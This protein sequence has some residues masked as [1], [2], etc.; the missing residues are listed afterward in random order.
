MHTTI[1]ELFESFDYIDNSQLEELYNFTS[2][3]YNKEFKGFE[4]TSLGTNKKDVLTFCIVYR[5]IEE[6][7]DI[8]KFIWAST[9]YNEDFFQHT[10]VHLENMSCIKSKNLIPYFAVSAQKFSNKFLN[11]TIDYKLVENKDW[12]NS[13]LSSYTDK[14]LN[15][16]LDHEKVDNYIDKF[17]EVEKRILHAKLNNKLPEKMYEIKKRK[18]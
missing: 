2:Q 16:N 13:F 14:F 1:Y 8:N 6:P 17:L 9:S 10:L 7:C 15:F 3:M 5:F 18:I 12:I 4:N 11:S